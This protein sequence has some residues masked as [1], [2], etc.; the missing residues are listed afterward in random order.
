MCL[1]N[2]TEQN[3]KQH[4]LLWIIH[5]VSSS[6]FLVLPVPLLWLFFFVLLEK[7][8]PF[9]SLGAQ[10]LIL[11]HIS[12]CFSVDIRNIFLKLVLLAACSNLAW[13]FFC[14]WSLLNDLILAWWRILIWCHLSIASSPMSKNPFICKSMSG[15]CS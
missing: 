2:I 11:F 9:F 3:E 13:L 10:W 15:R 8:S 14:L 1:V 7:K 12:F 6:E 5:E 4:N